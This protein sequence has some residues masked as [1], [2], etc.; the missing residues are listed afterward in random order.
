MFLEQSTEHQNLIPQDLIIYPYTNT[1][2][3]YFTNFQI[4]HANVTV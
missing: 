1:S 4:I 3:M 2:L